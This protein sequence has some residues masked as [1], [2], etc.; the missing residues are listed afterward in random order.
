MPITKTFPSHLDPNNFEIDEFED[1]YDA[2]FWLGY[3]AG[4]KRATP[5][6]VPAEI[7]E[8]ALPKPM[9]GVPFCE[10]A[11]F[12]VFDTE[13]SG[14]SASA[15]AV[16]VAVGFFR[17]DGSA[18]GYYNKLWQL[19]A[20]VHLSASSVNVHGITKRRLRQEGMD[21]FFEIRAV[22]R[23][24]DTMKR[25]G[26]RIVA[27]NASFD[28][29]ILKQTARKHKFGEW[30][31]EAADVF[32][33]MQNSKHRCGIVSQKTGRLKN[34][35]NSELYQKLSGEAPRGAL[36]DAIVDIKVTGMSFFLGSQRGWWRM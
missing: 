35:S 21:A 5:P 1:P 26:K 36:H 32:C 34:P 16:Q 13:T 12:C 4:R 31:I 27:H 22:H 23:M 19:P 10:L 18:M 9:T 11:E 28:V 33:T 8:Q 6:A 17:A 29:R 30:S 15:C 3:F 20:G 24:F 7:E 14:L 2:F 25:R